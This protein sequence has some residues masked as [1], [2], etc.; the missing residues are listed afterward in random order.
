MQIRGEPGGRVPG[1]VVVPVLVR[2]RCRARSQAASTRRRPASPPSGETRRDAVASAAVGQRL[3]SRSS[4]TR[5][6]CGAAE[7]PADARPDQRRKYG[8]KTAKWSVP[9]GSDGSRG[10]GG[11]HRVVHVQR[12]AAAGQRGAQPL[13]AAVGVTR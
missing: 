3:A 9:A 2:R 8:V 12:A 5:T 4:G 1:Q 10:D 11:D 7:R 13:L 6:A